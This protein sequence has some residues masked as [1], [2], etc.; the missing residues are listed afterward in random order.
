MLNNYETKIA[1][2]QE[3]FNQISRSLL[4]ELQDKE[5]HEVEEVLFRSL[6]ELGLSFLNAYIEKKGTGKNLEVNLPYHKLETWNYIS[7]FGDMEI[8]N[9][10][11]WKKGYRG[12]SPI[13]EELNLPKQHFSYLLQKWTQMLCVDISH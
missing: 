10:Y 6:L 11:F 9:A 5:L 2:T 3:I 4:G 7:I 1:G 13:K 12:E 8:P